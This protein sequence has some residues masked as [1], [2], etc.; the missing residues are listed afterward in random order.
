[1][2]GKELFNKYA[3]PVGKSGVDKV[4]AGLLLTLAYNIGGDELF[5][6]LEKAEQEGKRLAITPE[7]RT[8]DELTVSD[9]YFIP[10][11]VR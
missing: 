10:Y 5:P 8:R 9:V 11:S 7:S 1:M 6:L 2:T 4:Y 3:N